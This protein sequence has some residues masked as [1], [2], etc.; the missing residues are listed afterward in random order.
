MFGPFRFPAPF[1][2]PSRSISVSVSLSFHLADSNSAM[3]VYHFSFSSFASG[4]L[5]RFRHHFSIPPPFPFPKTL[6]SFP[7]TFRSAFPP[8]APVSS[9]TSCLLFLLPHRH[10]LRLRLHIPRR[11]RSCTE[12]LLSWMAKVGNMYPPIYFIFKLPAQMDDE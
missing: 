10:L 12:A 8:Y 4:S 9:S 1:R 2:S 11:S 3:R 6:A 7:F 5:S